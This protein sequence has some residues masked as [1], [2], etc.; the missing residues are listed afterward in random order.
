MFW[1]AETGPAWYGVKGDDLVMEGYTSLRSQKYVLHGWIN[2]R[3]R[4][5]YHDEWGPRKQEMHLLYKDEN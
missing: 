4:W 1:N 3:Y 2:P 5:W